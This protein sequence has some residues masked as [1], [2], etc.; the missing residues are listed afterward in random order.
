MPPSN[1]RTYSLEP[2]AITLWYV[3][4]V[5]LGGKRL[6]QQL[7]KAIYLLL[8]LLQQNYEREHYKKFQVSAI[9]DLH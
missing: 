5:S 7:V 4:K 1:I 3:P 2:L 6:K 9:T 8:V